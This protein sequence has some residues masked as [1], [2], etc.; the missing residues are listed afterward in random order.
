MA[1]A[2]HRT[3]CRILFKQ[4]EILPV[5][6]QYILSL[7]GFSINNQEIFETN[8]SVCVCVC[9]CTMDTNIEVAYSTISGEAMAWVCGCSEGTADCQLSLPAASYHPNGHKAL[10]LLCHSVS[11]CLILLCHVPIQLVPIKQNATIDTL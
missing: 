2:Q 3:S 10:V 6:F 7:M 1:V 4:L 8:S 5:P 9:V 11:L